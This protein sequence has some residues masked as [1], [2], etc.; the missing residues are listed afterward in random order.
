MILHGVVMSIQSISRDSDTSEN[1]L[2]KIMVSS[3][4][5]NRWFKDL[6]FLLERKPYVITSI[7]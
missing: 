3:N 1:L 4:F 5:F 7:S 2:T 6:S